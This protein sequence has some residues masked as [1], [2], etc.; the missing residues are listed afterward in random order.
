V[1]ERERDRSDRGGDG[2][3]SR[4]KGDGGVGRIVRDEGLG[5]GVRR[6]LECGKICVRGCLGRQRAAGTVR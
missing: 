5:E 6:A 2:W 3:D 1:G 4:R